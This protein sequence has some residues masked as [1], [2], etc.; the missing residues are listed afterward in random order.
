[1]HALV[2]LG[3]AVLMAFLHL[4][5]WALSLPLTALLVSLMFYIYVKRQLYVL[6]RHLHCLEHISEPSLRKPV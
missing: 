6:L 4:M 3:A 2:T 5:E 1:M